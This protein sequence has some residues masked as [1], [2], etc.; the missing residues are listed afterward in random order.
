[1]H[2]EVSF[3]LKE[4]TRQ[5]IRSIHIRFHRVKHAIKTGM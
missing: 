2:V 3:H 4:G 1:M 5:L